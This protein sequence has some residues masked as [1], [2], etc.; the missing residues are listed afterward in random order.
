MNTPTEPRLPTTPESSWKSCSLHEFRRHAGKRVVYL[1]VAT[2]K[3]A[4]TGIVSHV[5][6]RWV[7]VHYSGSQGP[8][9][10]HPDNLRLTGERR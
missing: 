1:S 9:A 10:T 4:E 8:L 3:P 7:Y 5:D 6:D 2:G